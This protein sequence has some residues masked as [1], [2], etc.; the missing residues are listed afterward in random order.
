MPPDE[1]KKW[2][3]RAN[4]MGLLDGPFT[5]APSGEKLNINGWPFPGLGTR[6]HR[7]NMALMSRCPDMDRF[8]WVDCRRS[9]AKGAKVGEATEGI[10]RKLISRVYHSSP[11][12]RLV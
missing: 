7:S 8:K 5:P 4:P 6:V 3:L 1:S 11:C 9:P 10:Y 12:I 2:P